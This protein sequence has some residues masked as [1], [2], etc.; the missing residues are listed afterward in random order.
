MSNRWAALSSLHPHLHN[1]GKGL[2]ML[3]NGIFSVWCINFQ[4][5]ARFSFLWINVRGF[6]KCLWNIRR[7]EG[8]EEGR[9]GGRGG[10]RG[11]GGEGGGRGREKRGKGGREGNT[12]WQ[13]HIYLTGNYYD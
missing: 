12:T 3:T 11:G 4:A 7:R 1:N 2:P 6:E 13:V 10:G 9:E 8:R 5:M